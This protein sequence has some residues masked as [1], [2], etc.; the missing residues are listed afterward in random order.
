[1]SII[2]E[3][4]SDNTSDAVKK[5]FRRNALKG[6]S[7]GKL[8]YGHK[9]DKEGYITIDE[10]EAKVVKQ[11]FEWSLSGIG[12]YTIANKLNDKG[13]KTKHQVINS[14]S[15]KRW[16]NSTVFGILKNTNQKGIYK[17]N[18][19]E[20]LLPHIAIVS[21]ETFDKVQLNLKKNKKN[22]VGKNASY[23]YLLNG[24]L[25]CAECDKRI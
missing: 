13:I 4:H 5:A 21:D 22:S 19:E 7:H 10:Y 24:L 8:S 1:M 23:N 25:F 14:K 6:K 9:K 15:N 12:S 17:W 16:Y 20:I 2:N 11:I 3:F 18:N